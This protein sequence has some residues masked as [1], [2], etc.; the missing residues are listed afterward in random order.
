MCILKFSS[1]LKE[2]LVSRLSEIFKIYVT[3]HSLPLTAI[4]I[5]QNFEKKKV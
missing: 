3:I 4:H 2:I 5:F 1:F